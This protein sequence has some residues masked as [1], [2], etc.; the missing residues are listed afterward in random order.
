[1]GP[2]IQNEL[3]GED[4]SVGHGG[5]VV[6]GAVSSWTA[7]VLKLANPPRGARDRPWCG[8]NAACSLIKVSYHE[9]FE[10]KT[11]EKTN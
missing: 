6:K 4:D 2:V 7:Q 8:L 11:V 9:R 10:I 3:V 5:A 1:M